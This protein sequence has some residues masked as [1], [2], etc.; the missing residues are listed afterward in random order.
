MLK[1]QSPL[2]EDLERLAERVIGSCV[3]VH[4]VL[5]P[6]LV[7]TIYSR[8][9]ALELEFRGISFE[10]EKPI[11]VRYRGE[12]L[13][14]QRLDMLV[15]GSVV[16]ELKSVQ[17]VDSIHVAQVLSYLRVSRLRL[18]LLVNFNVPILKYGIRRVIL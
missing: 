9:V 14:H 12:L 13:C 16:L 1:I 7:E 4:R 18:G 17:R 15:G 6:G 11:A 8:A 5:G 3:A 2:P 10:R